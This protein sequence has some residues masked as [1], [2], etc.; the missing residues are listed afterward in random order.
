MSG[1]AYALAQE[2]YFKRVFLFCRRSGVLCQGV[3][4]AGSSLENELDEI[5]ED[6]GRL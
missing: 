6:M 1:I 4:Y 5:A 3:H 2:R